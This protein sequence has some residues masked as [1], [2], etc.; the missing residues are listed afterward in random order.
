VIPII[1]KYWRELIIAALLATVM[2]MH[3]CGKR[4]KAADEVKFN[5]QAAELGLVKG[6]AK[7]RDEINKSLSAHEQEL[8][9]KLADE[10]GNISSH[11]TTS[12]AVHDTFVAKPVYGPINQ[13]EPEKTEV[14]WDSGD[15]RFSLHLPEGTFTREQRFAVSTTIFVGPDG[16]TTVGASEFHEYSPATGQ[17]IPTSGATVKLDLAVVNQ[18]ATAPGP[19]HPRVVALAAPSGF[20]LGGQLNPWRGL[21]LTAGGLYGSQKG[22][23][24]AAGL[25]WRLRLPFLDST[26]GVSAAWLY[27][28]AGS[29]VAPIGSIELSR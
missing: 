5:A 17:E 3:E 24:G 1:I 21:I 20:G 25:G 12:V 6:V 23:Q 29:S 4:S 22:I 16:K 15:G 13:A 11:A 14:S 27:R 9:K 7:T 10:S 8:L 2:V 28:P 26:L 18:K 19:W